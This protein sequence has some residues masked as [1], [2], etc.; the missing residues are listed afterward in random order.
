MNRGRNKEDVFYKK[1]DFETFLY[2]IEEANQKFQ[3]SIHS[4]CLMSNHYHLLIE[5]IDGNLSEIM[6]HI[7]RNYVEFY[8]KSKGCDGSLFKSRFKSILIDKDEYLVDLTRYIHRNPINLVGDL[9]SYKW[10]SYPYYLGLSKSLISCFNKDKTLKMLG[11]KADISKYER[12]VMHDRDVDI[13]KK[14]KNLPSILANNE[15][16]KNL[17]IQK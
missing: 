11:Y 4:F 2:L 5:D 9:K 3:F 1:K 8:N 15:F 13:Y 6:H 7:N 14:R 12:F 16:R 17:H 10:S